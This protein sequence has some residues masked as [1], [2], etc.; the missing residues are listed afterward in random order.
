MTQQEEANQALRGIAACGSCGDPMESLTGTGENEGQYVCPRRL[1]GGPDDCPLPPVPAYPLHRLVMQSMLDELMTERTLR[2][3]VRGVQRELEENTRQG[4]ADIESAG[5]RVEQ[6]AW[7]PG[8][9]AADR[10]YMTDESHILR[11]ALN[12]DTYLEYEAPEDIRE[13]FQ[14]TIESVRLM[15]D[16]TT[17]RYVLPLPDGSSERELE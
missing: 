14:N 8:S 9:D 3:L 5:G 12:P 13:M 4:C 2:H 17:V 1:R 15:P 6:Q 11:N 16:R 7:D 10:A